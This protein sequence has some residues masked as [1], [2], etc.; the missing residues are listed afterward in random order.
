MKTTKHVSGNVSTLGH[1][2][3]RNVEQRQ[4]RP[5][6]SPGSHRVHRPGDLLRPA[7]DTFPAAYSHSCRVPA[8]R[9][10]RKRCLAT[11]IGDSLCPPA[12]GPTWVASGPGVGV[13]T[14]GEAATRLA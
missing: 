4:P 3:S 10:S 7:V 5:S 1:W 14:L 8:S 13:L 6:P 11:I 2:G 9:F 12:L